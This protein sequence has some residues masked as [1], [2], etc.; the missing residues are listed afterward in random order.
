MKTLS[1]E[2]SHSTI[3]TP[4]SL[5]QFLSITYTNIRH[6]AYAQRSLE[7]VPQVQAFEHPGPAMALQNN[8]EASALAVH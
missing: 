5:L 2:L 6:N 8:R 4:V 1:H 3:D 7:K